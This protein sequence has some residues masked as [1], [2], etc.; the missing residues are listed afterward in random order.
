MRRCYTS[1]SSAGLVTRPEPAVLTILSKLHY[2]H[3]DIR[4]DHSGRGLLIFIDDTFYSTLLFSIL[5]NVKVYS[6]C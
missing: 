4:F 1:S 5:G 6:V 3:E 2:Y